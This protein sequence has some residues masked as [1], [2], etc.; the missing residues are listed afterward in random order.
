MWREE[1]LQAVCVDSLPG[2]ALAMPGGYDCGWEFYVC[3]VGL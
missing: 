2:G 1:W 3:D